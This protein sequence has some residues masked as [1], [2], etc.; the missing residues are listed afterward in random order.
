MLWIAEIK[1]A[2]APELGSILLRVVAERQS[3][4]EY[5]VGKYIENHLQGK[6][7]YSI[8]RFDMI[9]EI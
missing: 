1:Y 2:N 6:R 8:S 7:V 5:K 9:N 3:I 4:A